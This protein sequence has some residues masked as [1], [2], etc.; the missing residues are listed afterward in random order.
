MVSALSEHVY[1]VDKFNV[2]DAAR[3]EFLNNVRRVHELLRTM[4]GFVQDLL[5]EQSSGPGVFN[6]VTIVEWDSQ[7]SIE[8]AK[9]SVSAAYARTKFDPQEVFERLDIKADLANYKQIDG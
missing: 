9:V 3:E 1:R 6:L 5:L 4:P 8:T 7:A 2:S